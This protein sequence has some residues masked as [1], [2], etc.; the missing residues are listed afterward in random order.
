L[1]NPAGFALAAFLLYGH[2]MNLPVVLV[3]IFRNSSVR[4]VARGGVHQGSLSHHDQRRRDHA[5]LL[6]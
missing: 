1:R 3:R 5:D 4:V 2:P 6:A